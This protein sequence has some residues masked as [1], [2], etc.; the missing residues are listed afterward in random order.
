ML[1][2]IIK[3]FN[4]TLCKIIIFEAIDNIKKSNRA[5]KSKLAMPFVNL[6]IMIV[7]EI[8]ITF[9]SCNKELLLYV[10]LLNGL[11]F[12]LI[13]SK[14]IISTMTSYP[15]SY[16]SIEVFFYFFTIVIALL[17]PHLEQ[18]I[19]ISQ[20]IFIISYYVYF[21]FLIIKQLMKELNISVF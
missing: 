11:Y 19:Y 6:F 2:Y 5:D 10:S 20:W 21:Y 12:G 18:V 17:F 13:V 8:L 16:P 3:S 1:F 15:L 4:Y 7:C 14:L 9:Y